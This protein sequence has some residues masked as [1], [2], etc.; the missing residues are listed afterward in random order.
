MS[1]EISGTE[2]DAA[3]YAAIADLPQYRPYFVQD[4]RGRGNRVKLTREGMEFCACLQA[5]SI[6][7][8]NAPQN[9][10]G[11]IRRYA[12][13]LPHIHLKVKSV[14]RV[15]HVQG[16]QVQAILVK[17]VEGRVAN[18]TPVEYRP[19]DRRAWTSGTIVGQEPGSTCLYISSD[20]Q[21]DQSDLPGVL[22]I[23]RAFM[24][25]QLAKRIE[26]MT[27]IPAQVRSLFAHRQTRGQSVH[28]TDAIDMA[29][30]LSD[31]A[32]PWTK[33]LWG[34][35]GSGKTFAIAQYV[36]HVMRK[37]PDARILLVAP[38]NLAVDVL[39]EELVARMQSN[40]LGDLVRARSILRYGYPR[41]NNILS[42]PELLGPPEAD[43]LMNDI[44]ECSH[45]ITEAEH[46]GAGE[47]ELA[48][49]RAGLLATQETL[50]TRVQ[51]HARQARVI[52]TSTTQAYLPEGPISDG[53][54]QIVAVDEATMVHPALCYYL[55]SLSQDVLLLAGDPRQL[56][57]VAELQNKM[58]D[59]ER[60]WIAD[61]I[62]EATGVSIG[63]SE[64][65]RI[66]NEHPVLA[67][68][69]EQR[70]CAAT[71]W[72]E[73]SHLYPGVKCVRGR[74][75]QGQTT[76][77]EPLPSSPVT[78]VDTAGLGRAPCRR[79]KHSWYNESSAEL[80]VELA[81]SM[82]GDTVDR[83]IA[84]I[85]PFRT[86]VALLKRLLRYERSV[87]KD[88]ERIQVGTVHQ[89]QGSAADIVIFD[90]VEADVRTS[91]TR[92]LQG[93][94]GLRL[95]NVAI[96]RARDKLVVV[97]NRSWHQ[98][99]TCRE[100][101]P[102]LWNLVL[103][104]KA[105]EVVA[106]LDDRRSSES[107]CLAYESPSEAVLGEAMRSTGG[108]DDVVA[109]YSIRR[110]DG[111]LISRADFAVPQLQYAI[112]RSIHKTCNIRVDKTT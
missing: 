91:L 54:W 8:S 27:S 48:A 20:T 100:T 103:E 32:Q 41:S 99:H 95:V 63:S 44:R 59:V 7:D 53:E 28:A 71:I 93:D 12:S 89:F 109:Q 24:F 64:K 26:Q 58:G 62:F 96:S 94:M 19:N 87:C 39:L 10:A 30:Q 38:S 73:I 83:S 40:G 52:A 66:D 111:S 47:N 102:L 101:N 80:C 14:A 90:V 69:T 23:D 84:I 72:D 57:P 60:K 50:R 46:S 49:L 6:P 76:S 21:I 86:Q 98:E 31:L 11:A 51:N 45:R 110:A 68:I 25:A 104:Y 75:E 61:D 85:T 33:L 70:R 17:M 37:N 106:V 79:N 88:Y 13:R 34:P 1:K 22:A 112:Y 55:G 4:R 56:G 108:L 42:L 35:P 9:V 81:T 105:S 92:I 29:I 43:T 74:N 97:A 82:L 2:E 65:R 77:V 3:L 67:R 107:G 16:K 18:G 78:L 5:P 15:A 36:V